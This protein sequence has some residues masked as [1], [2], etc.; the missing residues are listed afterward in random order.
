VSLTEQAITDDCIRNLAAAIWRQV[1]RDLTSRS[2]DLRVTARDWLLSEAAV[3]WAT[4]FDPA[5][6]E[7]A[8]VI[9]AVLI[10]GRPVRHTRY[11]ARQ[12]AVR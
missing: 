8:I 6:D 2:P 4:H 11:S 5:I 12:R 1:A 9:Q 3:V 10:G 7:P